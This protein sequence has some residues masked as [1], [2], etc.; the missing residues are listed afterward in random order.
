MFSYII[1]GEEQKF[2]KLIVYIAVYKLAQA[3]DYNY[4]SVLV[5]HATT[6]RM[7][8]SSYDKCPGQ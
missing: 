4:E 8:G 1:R 3:N 5:I 6:I 7:R 2:D